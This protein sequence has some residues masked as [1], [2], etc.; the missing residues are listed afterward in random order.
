MNDE[1]L[2]VWPDLAAV[3]T[4]LL[5]AVRA[6]DEF[7]EAHRLTRLSSVWTIAEANGDDYRQATHGASV[8]AKIIAEGWPT[9]PATDEPERSGDRVDLRST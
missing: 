5:L 3:D 4:S 1:L 7:R 8:L 9:P 2:A 6:A